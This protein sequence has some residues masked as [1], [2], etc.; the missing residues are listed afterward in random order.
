MLRSKLK[1]SLALILTLGVGQELGG[2]END[3]NI[4]CGRKN[5]QIKFFFQGGASYQTHLRC[6]RSKYRCLCLLSRS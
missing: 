4:A 3:E 6:R 2:N 5:G 1:A